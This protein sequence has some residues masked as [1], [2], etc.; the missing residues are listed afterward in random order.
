[1]SSD[2]SSNAVDTR[3][4]VEEILDYFEEKFKKI[5]AQFKALPPKKTK[6]EIALKFVG[7]KYQHEFNEEIVEA[8]EKVIELIEVGS[9]NR[10]MDLIKTPGVNGLL[11]NITDTGMC[12]PGFELNLFWKSNPYLISFLVIFITRLFSGN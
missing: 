12:D 2:N 3:G 6:K 5:E 9:K 8:L 4:P 7:N 10:S 11:P 1:M